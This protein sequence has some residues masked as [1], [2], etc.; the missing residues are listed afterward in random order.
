MCALKTVIWHQELILTIWIL[1]YAIFDM[2][3]LTSSH[4][5]PIRLATCTGGFCNDYFCL[6]GLELDEKK[7]DQSEGG[8]AFQHT[9]VYSGFEWPRW[10]MQ[11][12]AVLCSAL[13]HFAHRHHG[14]EPR[15]LEWWGLAILLF[16]TGKPRW[17]LGSLLAECWD[18]F[19]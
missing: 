18:K 10:K 1:H 15:F 2:Y 6:V 13:I 16:A 4:L 14:F 17:S 5:L 19:F 12:S 11:S 7:F 8:N 9:M 3:F